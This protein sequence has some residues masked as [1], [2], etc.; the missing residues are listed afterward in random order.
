MEIVVVDDGSTVPLREIVEARR[1][2]YPFSIR[3]VS[4]P[5]SGP[6]K[7]RNA[8]FHASVN[9]ILLF[10]DDD[11]LAFPDLVARHYQA[12]LDN[13]GCIVFGRSPFL[14]PLQETL[15]YR[16]LVKLLSYEREREYQRVN[17]VA[18]GNISVE[19][20][21]FLP[22]GVYRD[23]LRTPAAEE[24]ELECRLNSLGIPI[25][26]AH[27][28]AGWHLQPTTI[29]EKCRQ[30]FKYGVGAAE[31]WVKISNIGANK[32]LARIAETNGYVAWKQDSTKTILKKIVKL[33]LSQAILR[34]TLLEVAQYL[35]GKSRMEVLAFR[36]FDL[37][38]GI[39][40][41][42]GFRTGLRQFRV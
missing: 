32:H 13:P 14:Q 36:Y 31:A 23:E 28:A 15:D 16:Y 21:M 40:L 38:C 18:S 20:K 37:I 42:S 19:R 6:A 17:V 8:G 3:Y 10:V 41:F 24:F 11:I 4:Q 22:D 30:E 25:I 39:Y 26:F 12:H 7:A 29:Q 34:T 27:G 33:V 2:V 5:N 9:D 35:G 1:V